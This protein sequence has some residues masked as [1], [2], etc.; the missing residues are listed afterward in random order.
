MP[1]ASI[2]EGGKGRNRARGGGAGS[3]AGHSLVK[4]G[5][6]AIIMAAIA[7][8]AA[9]YLMGGARAIAPPSMP[10][11]GVAV[12][13]QLSELQALSGEQASADLAGL[14]Q[15][16]ISGMPRINMTYNGY[17][18]GRLSGLGSLVSV[19]SPVVVSYSKAGGN[20]TVGTNITGLPI[21]GP[22]ELT[23]FNGTGGSSLCT[24]LNLTALLSGD[25]LGVKVKNGMIC[26]RSDNG[27]GPYGIDVRGIEHFNLSVLAQYGIYANLTTVYQSEYNGMG[28]TYLAG[29][30]Y[31]PSES[32]TGRFGLCVA[33]RSLVPLTLY[34]SMKSRQGVG[35]LALNESSFD[36]QVG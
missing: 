15:E 33:N 24:N 11:M 20:I 7:A 13:A 36:D 14:M 1:R 18:Y 12:P 25:Y 3:A 6:I 26:R 29:N 28:C 5:A 23:L 10:D 30:L 4:L 16:R 22:G 27:V 2:G 21:A 8:L 32:G 17:V 9:Y 31:Q 34:L 35:Y 19:G